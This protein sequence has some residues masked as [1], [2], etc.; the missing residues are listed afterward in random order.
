MSLLLNSFS[1]LMH[2]PH[3]TNFGYTLCLKNDTDAVGCYNFNMHLPISVIFGRTVVQTVCCRTFPPHLTN[4]SALPGETQKRENGAFQILLHG[5][6]TLQLVIQLA[7]KCIA[8][9]TR[10][11]K[12]CLE[13]R[14]CLENENPC[15]EKSGTVLQFLQAYL[16]S[17]T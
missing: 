12:T 8:L 11:L 10:A 5:I 15:L 9:L 7:A 2:L 17:F 13:A 4:V 14:T 6:Y 1:P 16:C 3:L